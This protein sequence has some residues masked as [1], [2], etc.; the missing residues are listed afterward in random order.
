[1]GEVDERWL[2]SE[3]PIHGECPYCKAERIAG[4]PRVGVSLNANTGIHQFI[5]PM[6]QGAKPIQGSFAVNTGWGTCFI[7]GQPFHGMLPCPKWAIGEC[8]VIGCE[9]DNLHNGYCE[10]HKDN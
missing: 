4:D 8:G 3:C 9:K 2:M 7:C 5:V 1:M 6:Q 10:E